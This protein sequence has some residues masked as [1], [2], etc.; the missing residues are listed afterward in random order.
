M[1]RNED[2][3]ETLLSCTHSKDFRLAKLDLPYIRHTPVG[4]AV[5]PAEFVTD[6]ASSPKF[7]WWWIPPWGRYSGAAVIHD[8]LYRIKPKGITREQA[9]IIMLYIMK[10]D[11]VWIVKRFAIFLFLRAV[12]WIGWLSKRVWVFPH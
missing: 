10:I 5:V 8:W 7:I 4:A 2:V 12:G 1:I 3:E 11:K 9:D 6:F